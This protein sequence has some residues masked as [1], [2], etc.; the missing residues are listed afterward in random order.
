MQ[1]DAIRCHQCVGLEFHFDRAWACAAYEGK[2]KEILHAYKF[3]GRKTL[4]PF[5]STLLIRFAK[6]YVDTASFDAVAA[7]PLDAH[8]KIERGFNQSQ[9]LSKK[10]AKALNL[11]DLSGQLFRKNASSAQSLLSR[12]ARMLNVKNVFSAHPEKSFSSKRVLLIDDI[13]T[14]GLTA[15]EC[16]KAIKRA[17][18]TWVSALAVA[19]GI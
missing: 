4:A 2:M 17:G 12:E 6:A 11:P 19:R 3:R 14:T 16:A 9:L 5:F 10:I 18:A 15:S 7:V 13:L 8:K 1:T